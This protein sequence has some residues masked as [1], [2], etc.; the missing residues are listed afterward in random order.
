MKRALHLM[1]ALRVAS[2]RGA[3]VAEHQILCRMGS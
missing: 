2:A 3:L 1:P